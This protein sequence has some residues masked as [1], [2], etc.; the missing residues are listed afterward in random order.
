[1]VSTEIFSSRVVNNISAQ[2]QGLL[3]IRG[4]HGVIND[5]KRVGAPLVH[6]LGNAGDISDLH[7]G[8]GGCLQQDQT[9]LFIEVRDDGFRVGGV[10]VV[11]LDIVVC[12]QEAQESVRA[13]V[14]VE[15]NGHNKNN[16]SVGGEGQRQR[17]GAMVSIESMNDDFPIN[18]P[19][20]RSHHFRANFPCDLSGHSP[21]PLSLSGGV[22]WGSYLRKDRF[23]Q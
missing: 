14:R 23:R 3:E 18:S 8:V 2:F 15:I 4:H 13:C 19:T 20:G 12:C 9:S 6:N 10:D 21:L 7:H 1:M 22:V 17:K 11:G 5:D 16:E